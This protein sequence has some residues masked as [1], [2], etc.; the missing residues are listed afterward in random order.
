VAL[1]VTDEGQLR[2]LVEEILDVGEFAFDCE[3]VGTDLETLADIRLDP[4]KNEVVWLSFATRGKSFTLPIGHP[5]GEQVGTH[6]E[7]RVGSDGKTRMFSVPTWSPAPRQ[8]EPAEAFGILEPLFFTVGVLKIGHNIKFDLESIMKYYDLDVPPPD[9]F[10][11]MIALQLLDE[12]RHDYR[13]GTVIKREFGFVYDKSLGQRIERYGF[14]DSARYAH[15]DAKWTWLLKERFEPMIA[16]DGLAG[17]H[18]LEMDVLEVLLYMERD[19]VLLDVEAATKLKASTGREIDRLKGECFREAGGREINFN[20]TQQM[21]Q[22]LF[23]RKREGG[24]G[25]KP[26]RRTK[27]GAP[28]T[29]RESIEL[30]ESQSPFV[31]R[32]LE[33]QDVDKVHGTYLTAYLGGEVEKTSSGKTTVEY[34][35]SIMDDEGRI[36]ANFKQTGTVTGRFSCVAADTLVD[37]PRDLLKQP[38]GVPITDVRAGDLVYAFDWRRDLVLRRVKW[39]AQT[40][41]KQTVV[42]TARDSVGNE[43]VL[44]LTPDHLVRMW[45]GDWRPAGSLMHRWGDAVRLDGPRV[46]T[47]VRRTIEDGYVR[48][49]PHAVSGKNGVIGGGRNREH[50][51]VMTAVRGGRAVSTK[52]DVHHLDGNRAN[53]AVGNLEVVDRAEH[54]GSRE[55]HPDWGQRPRYEEPVLYTGPNDFRVVSVEPG[56]VEPVWDM[57]VEDAH[58]FIANGYV[59]HNCSEPNLQNIPRPDDDLGKQV[60]GLFIAPPGRR[61]VVADYGQIEY[62]VMAHFS[63]DPMLVRAFSDGT[64]L[65]QY[66][67]AMVFGVDMADVTKTQRGTAKNTNFAVAYGAGDDKVAAMSGITLAEAVAFRAAHRKLL[68]TLYRWSDQAVLQARQLRPPGVTTLMGRKRRLPGLMFSDW[69]PRKAAERQA[70]N[71]IVQGSAADIIKLAMVR[72]HRMCDDEMRLCLSVHDELLLEVPEHR[73]TDGQEA[74]REAMLGEGI[75]R[76]L[77]V[78]MKIDMHTVTRW[79]E[80]KE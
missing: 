45:T 21:Q 47:M 53:N 14:K 17:V 39:V 23:G 33:L 19:A 32:Y 40:G 6:K 30:Y 11:T 73:V 12:N 31:A 69:G 72:L 49:Y 51:F 29:A 38:D 34:R 4:W 43:R 16:P 35:P 28:S 25:L 36:H 66:V 27:G 60:R 18:Q 41:V 42:V 52:D 59:V 61:L 58:C 54:R 15:F 3:T 68:P 78:P 79:S 22:L 9:Y 74:M 5:H 48:I 24:L 50:R 2:D 65:H 37:M 75:Q 13:L 8:I 80:A 77:S 7:P 57:E 44:R 56:L 64:D 46:L 63:R 70:V 67:A 76:L 20:S 10:D 55:W 26:L 1:I 62:V 71:T